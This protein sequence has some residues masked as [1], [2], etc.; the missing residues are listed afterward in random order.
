[1]LLANRASTVTVSAVEGSS[2]HPM[3]CAIC[4]TPCTGTC[5]H[6]G[7]SSEALTAAVHFSSTRFW[8]ED[9]HIS[10]ACL[11]WRYSHGGLLLGIL[12]GAIR[13]IIFGILLSSSASTKAAEQLCG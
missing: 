6:S 5:M 7:V 4:V 10:V 8:Q 13:D 9:L 12:G 2:A 3:P 11:C 1:M